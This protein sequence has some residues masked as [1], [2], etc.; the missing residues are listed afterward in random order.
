MQPNHERNRIAHATAKRV[1]PVGKYC[2]E[3]ITVAL[4]NGSSSVENEQERAQFTILVVRLPFQAATSQACVV[5]HLPH[6]DVVYTLVNALALGNPENGSGISSSVISL[7]SVG[8]ATVLEASA[9]LL[10]TVPAAVYC[11]AAMIEA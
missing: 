6:S 10:I 8:S 5:R 11:I 9:P 1:A 7:P 2:E 3:E 4:L